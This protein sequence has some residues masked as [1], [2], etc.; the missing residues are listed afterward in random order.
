MVLKYKRIHKLGRTFSECSGILIESSG[1]KVQ[2]APPHGSFINGV[3]NPKIVYVMI[4]LMMFISNYRG[5][6]SKTK[7]IRLKLIPEAATGGV[8]EKKL[9]LEFLNISKKAPVLESLFH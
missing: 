3:T 9:F 7:Q 1:S 5:Q 6:L 8:L 4:C 2:L